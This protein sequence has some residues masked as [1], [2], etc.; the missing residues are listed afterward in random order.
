MFLV[1]GTLTADL[2]VFSPTP[3]AQLGG[4][5]FRASNLVFTDA[6]LA[7]FMGGNGG[8]SA[9]VAAGLGIPTALGGAVG[10]DLLGDALVRWLADRQV[11]LSG[12]LRSSTH[13]TSSST[14]VLTDA[15]NQ[16]VFHHL[17]SSAAATLQAIPAAL[18]ERADVLLATSFSLLPHFRAGGF[19]Q[20]LHR[21]HRRGGITGLDIGP[22]I[23]Q[24]VTLDEVRPLLADVDY[25]IGNSHELAVLT[26]AANWEEAATT[27]L[28]AG[29]PGVVIK[30][31]EAGASLWRAGERVH[32]P[33]FPVDVKISVGAGDSFNVGFLYAAARGWSPERA[34]R[35]G[36]GVAARV[37]AHP[38]GIFGAPTLAQVHEFIGGFVDGWGEGE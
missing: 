35:F 16:A 3:L 33:A 25:L 38:Q 20:A 28:A 2:L 26:G 18:L 22:A 8:N 11:D 21:V 30:Q 7:I 37:M 12:L 29:A 14:I 23:G 13:A 36:N 31:G 4:D 19:A 15:A 6:P 17:G 24:P 27:L 5:G 34:L 32:A 9:Y 1:I 10:Q